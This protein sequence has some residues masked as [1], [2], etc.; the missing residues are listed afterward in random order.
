M[1]SAGSEFDEV[2]A[3]RGK[4]DRGVNGGVEMTYGRDFGN[5]GGDE[6]G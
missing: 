1:T 5:W 3:T 6:L 2:L 4:L